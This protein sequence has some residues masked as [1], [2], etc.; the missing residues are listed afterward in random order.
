[1]S[2]VRDHLAQARKAAKMKPAASTDGRRIVEAMER[3]ATALEKIAK[4]SKR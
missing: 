1:M 4:E 3:I 2:D